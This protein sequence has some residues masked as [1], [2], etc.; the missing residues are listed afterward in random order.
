VKILFI[1][2]YSSLYGANRSLLLLLKGL[3]KKNIE[4]MVF[5]PEDGP[6]L[7]E[8]DELK[9]PYKKNKFW[10][11]MGIRN[12]LFFLKSP[13]RFLA[14]IFVLP[15]LLIHTIKFKPSIIYTNSSTTPVGIYL[16]LILRLPHIWH[17]RE[18]GKSDYELDY[19]FGKKYFNFFMRKSDAIICISQFV[20]KSV[21]EGNWKNVSIINN[22][23]YSNNE[24]EE[25]TSTKPEKKDNKFKFLMMTLIHPSKGIE[26]AIEALAKLK[27][28]NGNAKLVIC[29]GVE[30]KQYKR[31][32]DELVIKFGLSEFVSFAGFVENP[33]E[34]YKKADAVLVCSKNEAWGRVAAE[35]MIL[36][37][38]V[39][40]FNGGGT[41]EIIT[42]NV[43]GLLYDNIDELATCMKTVMI[44]GELVKVIVATA[45]KYTLEN[46]SS[47]KYTNNIFKIIS[48]VEK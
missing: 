44:D 41:K 29:G 22:A 46:F 13:L 36:E 48:E 25:I 18:L 27:D 45:K 30:D 20:K 31:Q 40:G 4:F 2:H 8:L 39:I 47:E 35:A 9:I 3:K 33:I 17:V 37:K 6:L 38:P 15:L 43:N 26:D 5:T 10:S 12:K 34:K 1:T 16:S 11:W 19:D 21:F 32:L 7:K 42:N 28:D 24:I 23:V 14:N